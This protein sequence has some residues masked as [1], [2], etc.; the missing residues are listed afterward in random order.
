MKNVELISWIKQI[1][2]G[3][4]FEIHWLVVLRQ[5]VFKTCFN[6]DISYIRLKNVYDE[7][8]FFQLRDFAYRNSNIISL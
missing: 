1:F 4:K 5:M 6:Y 2:G 8:K 3:I 7:K